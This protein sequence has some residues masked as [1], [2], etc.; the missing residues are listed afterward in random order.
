MIGVP[1][2]NSIGVVGPHPGLQHF[3]KPLALSVSVVPEVQEEEKEDQTVEANDVDEDGKLIRAILYEEILGD[4]GGHQ[5]ELDLNKTEN[6]VTLQKCNTDTHLI[7]GRR[8]SY[9][10]NGGEVLLPPQVLLVVG[11]HGRQPIVSVHDD[12]DHT[13]QQSMERPHPTWNKECVRVQAQQTIQSDVR[14]CQEV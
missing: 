5:H 6:K 4:V 1:I 10:L 13:V 8:Y 12:M 9:Q 7:E 3:R 2:N 11:A 14:K